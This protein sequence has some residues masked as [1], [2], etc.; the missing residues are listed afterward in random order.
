[1]HKYLSSDIIWALKFTVFLEFQSLKTVHICRQISML[2][3]F[4]PNKEMVLF[5]QE[6]RFAFLFLIQQHMS[7]YNKVISVNDLLL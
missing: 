6:P 2:Y 4:R 3:I 7:L 5:L 1:M